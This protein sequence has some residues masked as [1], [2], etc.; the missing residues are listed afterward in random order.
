MAFL[1]TLLA[2]NIT[3]SKKMNFL[4]Y[5][6]P[7]EDIS[8]HGHL[9]DELFGF[10]TILVAFFFILVCL[11]LFGFSYRYSKKRS[12]KAEYTHGNRKKQM[13]G[14]IFMGLFVFMAIDM[15]IVKM[16][17]ND[18]LNV[19]MN[20]PEEDKEDVIRIE[21]LAQQWAWSFRY[22]GADGT[23][24][25]DD[26]IVT[27]NDLRLPIGKK[28]VLQ[29]ISKDVIHSF[30]IPNARRK[31]DAMPGRIS[32]V[33]YEFTKA[34]VWD[35]ACAEMCGTNHY[36]MAAKLTTYSPEEYKSWLAEAQQMAYDTLEEN[37][38]DRYW[39][40]KWQAKLSSNQ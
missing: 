11:V 4:D 13:L 17:N 9:I 20:F 33:W 29:M 34:G 1:T 37:N 12:P 2:A 36:K 23:F 39:G 19:F 10:T 38:M 30:W 32:R 31:V 24:N 8:V 22:S 21:V 40:W 5:F 25:T 26:D 7:P 28:V 27:F 16:S 6:K 3:A 15:N 18:A 35:I 14:A